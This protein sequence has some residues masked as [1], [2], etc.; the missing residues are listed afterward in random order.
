MAR[1]GMARRQ[2][3]RQGGRGLKSFS[4]DII[5]RQSRP[6]GRDSA[7]QQEELPGGIQLESIGGNFDWSLDPGVLHYRK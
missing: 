7:G 3:L 1:A 4:N 6:A 5:E 2:I